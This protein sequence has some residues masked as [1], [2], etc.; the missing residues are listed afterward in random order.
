MRG[1]GR[2]SGILRGPGKGTQARS[3]TTKNSKLASPPLEENEYGWYRGSVQQRASEEDLKKKPDCHHSSSDSR[4]TSKVPQRT[5]KRSL[6]SPAFR[7]PS[8]RKT[9]VAT[10]ASS[11]K[12]RPE[13]RP[14]RPGASLYEHGP[15]A[16][17][18]V[19]IILNLRLRGLE[20]GPVLRLLR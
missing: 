9:V 6:F 8:P 7:F 19:L 1:S 20:R 11:K 4:R 2:H 17:R 10:G 5:T 15:G 3:T 13:L 12:S 18:S 14:H 16:S